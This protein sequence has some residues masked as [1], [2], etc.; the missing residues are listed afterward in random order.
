[1][2][3]KFMLNSFSNNYPVYSMSLLRNFFTEKTDSCIIEKVTNFV[4]SNE[5][6]DEILVISGKVATGKTHLGCAILNEIEIL[7]PEK[8]VFL[9]SFEKLLYLMGEDSVDHILNFDFLDQQS[10]VFIDGFYESSHAKFEEYK[11]TLFEFIVKTKTKVVFTCVDEQ[12]DL[13]CVRIELKYY[14]DVERNRF[15][16]GK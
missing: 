13:E 1:M 10:I 15:C 14:D 12:I 11:I 16:F 5:L 9:I 4:S 3:K 2:K 7:R 6:K 8:S